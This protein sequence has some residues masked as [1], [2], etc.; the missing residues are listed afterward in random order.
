MDKREERSRTVMPVLG[1]LT[2]FTLDTAVDAVE[3][4]EECLGRLMLVLVLVLIEVL[5][6]LLLMLCFSFAS[7]KAAIFLAS[8]KSITALG[9]T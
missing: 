3:D 8:F 7:R 4:V 2:S 5:L 6:V 1:I 9:S